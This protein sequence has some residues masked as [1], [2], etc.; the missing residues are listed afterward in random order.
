MN[1]MKYSSLVTSYNFTAYSKSLQGYCV[2]PGFLSTSL[3]SNN[4][5]RSSQAS[6][7]VSANKWKKV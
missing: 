7:T 6:T 1:N 4:N 3:A 5:L 2:G